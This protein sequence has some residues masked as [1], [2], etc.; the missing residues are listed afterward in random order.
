LLWVAGFVLAYDGLPSHSVSVMEFLDDKVVPDARSSA[1]AFTLG[2]SNARWL[3]IRSNLKVMA[4]V[5]KE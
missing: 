2:P 1:D 4:M 3:K 5:Q